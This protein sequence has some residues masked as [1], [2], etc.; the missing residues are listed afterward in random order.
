[1]SPLG[2]KKRRPKREV[3]ERSGCCRE[4]EKQNKA[5]EMQLGD[6]QLVFPED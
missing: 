3:C 2:P 6:Y 5:K 4:T 1:M